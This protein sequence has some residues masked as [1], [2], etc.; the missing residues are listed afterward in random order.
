MTDR[1]QDAAEDTSPEAYKRGTS[2]SLDHCAQAG[3]EINRDVDAEENTGIESY[4]RGEPIT[5][6]SNGRLD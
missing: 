3:T 4:K 1:N 5:L 6:P 2:S